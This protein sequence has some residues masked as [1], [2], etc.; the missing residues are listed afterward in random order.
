MAAEV[1]YDCWTSVRDMF[2][3]EGLFPIQ[4]ASRV[5]NFPS[6]LSELESGE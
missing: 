1:G 6:G 2:G 5:D 3:L 4:A